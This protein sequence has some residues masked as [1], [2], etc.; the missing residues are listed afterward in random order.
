MYQE[1]LRHTK[2]QAEEQQRKKISKEL[3]NLM[4]LGGFGKLGCTL[5]P[6]V[7][8]R[9]GPEYETSGVL[10][11]IYACFLI[12]H[13]FCFLCAAA[14][15]V[16]YSGVIYRGEKIDSID[17]LEYRVLCFL[18]L[19]RFEKTLFW[20]L[21]NSLHAKICGRRLYLCQGH[22]KYKCRS[23]CSHCIMG[24]PFFNSDS[25]QMMVCSLW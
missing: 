19:Y 17:T 18:I 13:L 12:R 16:W 10:W 14:V 21:I 24:K 5:H 11:D 20:F 25:M 3:S 9:V 1:T 22:D 15:T 7:R 2:G 6:V 4:L 8:I 23:H